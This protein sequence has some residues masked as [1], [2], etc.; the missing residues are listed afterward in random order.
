MYH[1]TKSSSS[2]F[3]SLPLSFF[4]PPPSLSLCAAP[5]HM[6]MPACNR[7]ELPAAE[8]LA[9]TAA[10]TGRPTPFGSWPAR[11]YFQRAASL[12]QR[13]ARDIR[14]AQSSRLLLIAR[15]P[16]NMALTDTVVRAPSL[17]IASILSPAAAPVGDLSASESRGS[18]PT[19]LLGTLARQTRQDQASHLVVLTLLGWRLAGSADSDAGGEHMGCPWHG[20][21]HS[22]WMLRWKLIQNQRQ[23]SFSTST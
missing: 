21:G 6:C 20:H 7:P 17:A 18:C 19:S 5:E 4:R 9:M 22:H 1:A 8:L 11:H 16:S 12:L 10:A 3:L 14:R 23:M 2:V 15:A 13:P